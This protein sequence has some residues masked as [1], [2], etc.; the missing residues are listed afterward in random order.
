[1][2]IALKKQDMV[3]VAENKTDPNSLYIYLEIF[4]RK[5]LYKFLKQLPHPP[6]FTFWGAP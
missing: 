5:S 2:N 1:M 4:T 3:I 6:Q